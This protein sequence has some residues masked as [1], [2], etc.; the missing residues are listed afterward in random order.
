MPAWTAAYAKGDLWAPDVSYHNAKYWLYYAA[1]SFGKNTSAIGLATSTT[2]APGSW[3]DQGIVL[4]SQLSDNFNAIDPG[5][6][7]DASGKWWLSFGSFWG[8]LKLIEIDPVTGKRASWNETVYPLAHRPASPAIEAAFIF[9]HGKYYFLFASFDQ[10]CR[11]VESTYHIVVGRSANVTG[12]YVDRGGVA[13][14]EVGGSI[15]LSTH[16]RVNGPGGQV[17]IHADG[18]DFLIYHYYD[19]NNQGARTLGINRI[20]WDS[21]GWPNVQ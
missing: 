10:C 18:D 21:E 2:A 20:A 7:I 15:F 8:G 4:S 6:V 3:L 17:V 14:L 12:P 9:R 11:G 5:L 13:M 19:G 1:S 16:G